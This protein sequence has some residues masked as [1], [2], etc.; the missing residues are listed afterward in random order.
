MPSGN[1]FQVTLNW[2]K[3]KEYNCFP[4]SMQVVPDQDF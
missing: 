1:V 3:N 4:G 2:Y